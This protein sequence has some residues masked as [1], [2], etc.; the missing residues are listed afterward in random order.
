MT[1]LSIQARD[2]LAG[3]FSVLALYCVWRAI[4]IERGRK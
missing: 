3:I 1:L 4:R 2:V